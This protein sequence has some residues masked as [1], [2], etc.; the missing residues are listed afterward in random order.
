M[1]EQSKIESG[2]GMAL[3]FA[4][5]E[6]FEETQKA[7]AAW[8]KRRQEAME[9]GFR[10]FQAMC[11]CKD[12]ASLAAAYSEWLTNTMNLITEEMNDTR[13]EAL[14]WG[15]IGQRSM[16]APFRTAVMPMAAASS[17]AAAEKEPGRVKGASRSE[18]PRERS[19]AE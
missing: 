1:S 14:R 2:F 8:M 11:A 9:A 17:P 7:M 16:A 10:S 12:P 6:L 4:S 5:P 19:A 3:P 13:N 15:E 18:T